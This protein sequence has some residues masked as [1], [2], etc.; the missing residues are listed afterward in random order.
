MKI[1]LRFLT[2]LTVAMIATLAACNNDIS[3]GEPADFA[4]GATRSL[5][6]AVTV[7]ASA[8]DA[9]PSDAGGDA[10]VDHTGDPAYDLQAAC[11]A[12]HCVSPERCLVS[13]GVPGAIQVTC[14]K[15]PC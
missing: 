14:G 10:S 3:C 15:G 4:P 2:A 12:L 13:S 1:S 6:L 9:T 7:D 11:A 8:P 5:S